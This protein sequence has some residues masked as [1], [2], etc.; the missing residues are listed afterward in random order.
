M[1]TREYTKANQAAWNQAAEIHKKSRFCRLLSDFQK[2]GFSLL[3]ETARGLFDQV[4]FINKTVG[5]AAC[6]NGRELLSLKNLGAGRC[7]GFD[8]SSQFL[9]Q[10]R[11]LAEASRQEVEFVEGDI[12]DIAG[13]YNGQ[14]DLVFS[15]IGVLGWMPDL[16]GFFSILRRLLKLEGSLM[17]YEMHP[18]LDMFEPHEN[19]NHPLP[20]YS[21]F[22]SDPWMDTNG[23]D[24]YT[25]IHY[26][27]QP[28]YYFHHTL[29][30]ILNGCID[31][32]FSITSFREYEHEISGE[33]SHFETHAA[34]YPLSFSLTAR[35]S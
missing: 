19:N 25:G 4:G 34:R 31:A 10:A 6:N 17:V 22:K 30:E 23:L 33:Y 13:E 28:T 3:D 35:A 26:D 24:Y 27:S 5:Q 12:Y 18:I 9:S 2:P 20:V 14:F 1:E 32:G 11:C 21:Y 8:I 15:T 7:V 16:G 29:S